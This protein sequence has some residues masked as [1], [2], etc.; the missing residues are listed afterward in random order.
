[1]DK[2]EPT[3]SDH[4]SALENQDKKAED[5][6]KA[7][8]DYEAALSL[9]GA[10]EEEKASAH[11][12]VR[13]EAD[14]LAKLEKEFQSIKDQSKEVGDINNNRELRMEAYQEHL[15]FLKEEALALSRKISLFRHTLDK[16]KLL[17]EL[18]K[19]GPPDWVLK[20]VGESQHK[21]NRATILYLEL[22]ANQLGKGN[23]LKEIDEQEALWEVAME[24]LEAESLRD[25]KVMARASWVPHHSKHKN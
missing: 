12:L 1:M 18:D 8:Q 19:N 15:N 21:K 22:A 10:T 2:K 9:E 16:D 5:L 25:N 23:L 17:D 24:R 20:Q 13:E 6:K 3:L 14:R 4:Q 7:E 11:E